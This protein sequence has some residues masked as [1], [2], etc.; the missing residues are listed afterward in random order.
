MDMEEYLSNG[1][2]IE[3]RTLDLKYCKNLAIVGEISSI[4]GTAGMILLTNTEIALSL[5]K[6]MFTPFI[7]GGTVMSILNAKDIVDAEKQIQK[8]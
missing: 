6:Y 5:S 8:T 4:I 1:E 7:I 3:A 2:T